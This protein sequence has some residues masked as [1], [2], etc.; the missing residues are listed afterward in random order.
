MEEVINENWSDLME[1]ISVS[2][3]AYW[4]L[5]KALKTKEALSV[6]ALRKPAKSVAFYREKAE[7]LAD[8]I[9]QQCSENPPYDLEH[10]ELSDRLVI[11]IHHYDSNRHFNFRLDNTYSSMRPIRAGVPQGLTLS[12]LLYSAYVNDILRPSTGVQLVLF[13]DDTAFFC[14]Q[15]ASG[16][17]F[18]VYRGPLTS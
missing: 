9:E 12:P 8:S 14:G 3:Q 5:T 2:H 7:C 16:R 10:L 13:A 15:I 4:G 18:R 6:S 17:F 11:I 1:E